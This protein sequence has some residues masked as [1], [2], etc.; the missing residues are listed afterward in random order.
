MSL[1]YTVRATARTF[2][3]VKRHHLRALR[4]LRNF[5]RVLNHVGF[6]DA[7]GRRRHRADYWWHTYERHARII[8]RLT[9]TECP[10]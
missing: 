2:P 4:A 3:Q 1:T 5:N 9:G 7:A 10:L 6:D 8:S